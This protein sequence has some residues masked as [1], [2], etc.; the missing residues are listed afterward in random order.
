MRLK[1]L[2]R[3]LYPIVTAIIIL[4]FIGFLV[5]FAT[6][7]SKSIDSA[8]IEEQKT[9]DQ[10][11]IVQTQLYADVAKRME[12]SSSTSEIASSSS[13]EIKNTTTTP[14]EVEKKPE[15]KS[16][17]AI[18]VLN[19]TGISGKAAELSSIITKGGYKVLVTGNASKREQI[20]LIKIKETTKK[21]FPE[22]VRDILRITEMLYRANE[23]TLDSDSPYDIVIVIG[24]N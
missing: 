20:T 12:S 16:L 19:S 8:L 3:H 6:F 11:L 14:I 24:M 23:V 7:I 1:S 5:F 10:E 4:V 21:L 15:N 9:K 22:S 17:I 2:S 13:I 18:S